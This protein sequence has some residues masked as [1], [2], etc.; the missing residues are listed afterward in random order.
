MSSS[1]SSS[2]GDVDNKD[3]SESGDDG[4]AYPINESILIFDDVDSGGEFV[5]GKI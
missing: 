1:S 3:N 2:S 4:G 5:S